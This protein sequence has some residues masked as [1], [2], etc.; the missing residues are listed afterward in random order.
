ML[1]YQPLLAT[2]VK[3]GEILHA[4]LR[5][6]SAHTQGGIVRFVEE[7]VA[8][9]RRAG[10][11]GEIVMRFD[12]GFWSKATI[13]TL[14]RLHQRARCRLRPDLSDHP[15]GP[16]WPQTITRTL[17]PEQTARTSDLAR[18]AQHSPRPSRPSPRLRPSSRSVGAPPEAALWIEE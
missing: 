10:A 14:G 6:G 12:W 7:H 18:P 8:R 17:T 5:K 15:G 2:W 11:S 13:A 16:A 9:V 1:G 3:I 4:R